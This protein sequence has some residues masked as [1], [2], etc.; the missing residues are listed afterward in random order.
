MCSTTPGID[1]F[2]PPSSRSPPALFSVL[3]ESQLA[4]PA[5]LE[6]FSRFEDDVF[7]T[8]DGVPQTPGRRER[9]ESVSA[10]LEPK[11]SKPPPPSPED[12]MLMDEF[13]QPSGSEEAEDA[14]EEPS[15]AVRS[16]KD[17]SSQEKRDPAAVALFE[18]TK[19]GILMSDMEE[20]QQRLEALIALE[21]NRME[22]ELAFLDEVRTSTPTKHLG[23]LG[24]FFGVIHG[25]HAFQFCFIFH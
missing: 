8:L 10:L 25:S 13:D 21:E 14:S 9:A 16:Q 22:D 23:W 15:L 4:E 17:A 6:D 12:A 19:H 5:P 11:P 2:D 1:Q 20:E 3:L 18:D 7:R 24:V